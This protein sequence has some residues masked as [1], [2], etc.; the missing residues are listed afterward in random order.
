MKTNTKRTIFS[1][2]LV[3]VIA[4]VFGIALKTSGQDRLN[5][6]YELGGFVA[7]AYEEAGSNV[8][9]DT[10]YNVSTN[11]VGDYNYLLL[12]T[13]LKNPGFVYEVGYDFGGTYNVQEGDKASATTYYTSITTAGATTYYADDIFDNAERG[14]A[15]IVWEVKYNKSATYTYSA[16]AKVGWI[17]EDQLW[18]YG[19]ERIDAGKDYAT[20]FYTVT[21]TIDAESVG[22]GSVDVAEIAEVPYGAPVSVVGNALTI[23]GTTVTATPA[24]DTATYDYEFDSFFGQGATVT[25]DTE[26]Y[27]SFT[28]ETRTYDITWKNDDDSVLRTDK[29][30][31]GATPSY[32]STPVSATQTIIE[33]IFNGWDNTVVNVAGNATYTAT[34][35]DGDGAQLVSAAAIENEWFKPCYVSSGSTVMFENDDPGYTCYYDG[36][37]KKIRAGS[38][39]AVSNALVAEAK[40]AGYNYLEVGIDSDSGVWISANALPATGTYSSTNQA[41]Y[42]MITGSE[43][44]VLDLT[45]ITSDSGYSQIAGV[46]QYAVH[47]CSAKFVTDPITENINFGS[48]WYCYNTTFNTYFADS[49]GYGGFKWAAQSNFSY[50]LPF[51]GKNVSREVGDYST[52]TGALGAQWASGNVTAQN[53]MKAAY[54]KAGIAAGYTKLAVKVAVS[55]TDK[56]YYW[57]NA[58]QWE[59]NIKTEGAWTDVDDD[60][61]A[62]MY[63]DISAFDNGWNYLTLPAID[64]GYIAYLDI[65]FTNEGT[66]L[67]P[68][69]MTYKGESAKEVSFTTEDTI[70]WSDFGYVGY[71]GAEYSAAWTLNGAAQNMA[72][73]GK[74]AAGNYTLTCTITNTSSEVLKVKSFRISVGE[75]KYHDFDAST[76]WAAAEYTDAFNGAT[77]SAG[78][79]TATSRISIEN[80]LIAAAKNHGYDYLVLEIGSDGEQY[81]EV[82]VVVTNSTTLDSSTNWDSYFYSHSGRQSFVM[83]FSSFTSTTGFTDI[84]YTSGSGALYVYSAKFVDTFI[85]EGVNYACEVYGGDGATTHYRPGRVNHTVW[86]TSGSGNIWDFRTVNGVSDVKVMHFDNQYTACFLRDYLQL[87]N[88]LGFTSVEMR[89]KGTAG[90]TVYYSSVLDATYEKSVSNH[91]ATATIAND[92]TATI[93][94][95]ITTADVVPAW[96]A[97]LASVSTGELI[98]DSFTFSK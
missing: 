62:T 18:S 8:L 70:E 84:I 10:K 36:N 80:A 30:A 34:Y 55:G 75:P 15:M 13:H 39:I 7:Y 47:L 63:I 45:N 59:T 90:A 38:G 37:T 52:D 43:C 72:T 81:V 12:V 46:N 19:E 6:N 98:V 54:V 67:A 24:A 20:A 85:A 66:N 14:D 94:I 60:G 73:S 91:N 9:G 53:Y 76:E 96:V 40:A 25:E 5:G 49:N 41:F 32:G 1:V 17:D 88:S 3:C 31:Y 48:S 68:I 35:V 95:D 21:I 50:M 86:A 27:V 65:H 58:R 4:C 26:I 87:A 82:N 42:D 61:L 16:Y 74:L 22:Y 28:R 57:A 29:L 69:T 93:T 44:V 92:G 11:K 79:I 71:S 78:A 51:A 89:I 97:Y 64:S 77:Y 23:N 33:K 2:L 56:V 83:D